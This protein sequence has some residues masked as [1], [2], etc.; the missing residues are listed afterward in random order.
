MS[1]A[2]PDVLE[3]V[4]QQGTEALGHKLMAFE[5][6][7]E[8]SR[9]ISALDLSTALG[10]ILRSI[11]E[12]TGT[13]RGVL[14]LEDTDGQLRCE[15]AIHLD[16]GAWQSEELAISRSV[17]EQARTSGE[18]V[19]IDD[20]P[21]SSS[22]D[23]PSIIELGLRALMAIPLRGRAGVF[24]VLYADTRAP[25]P[26]MAGRDPSI[27]LAFGLQAAIAIEN[28]RTHSELR[29]DCR[30]LR[31]SLETPTDFD[32]I[33]YRS[34]SMEKVCELIRS[35]SETDIT[36]LI[37]GETGTGKELVAQ[38]IR[39]HSRR[40]RAPFVSQN[41]G[42]LTDSLLESELF[43]HRRG[44]FSGALDHKPG[45]F[46]VADG[47]TVFLDEVAEASTAL[48]VRLLRLLETGTFRRV[49]ETRD[50]STDVRVI[51]ATHR[52]LP[53]ELAAGRF[54]E[55]LFYRLNVFPIYLPPLRERRE[56]IPILVEHFIARYVRQLDRELPPLPASILRYLID[57]PWPGNVRQLKNFVHRMVVL[58]RT[59]R[60]HLPDEPAAATAEPPDPEELDGETLDPERVATLEQVER[61]HVRRVL[62]SVG[63]NQTRAAG[64]LGLKRSTLRWRMKK[65]G[66][67]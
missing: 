38:A 24:G 21:S 14:L 23:R 4:R 29:N 20:A 3:L 67:S 40:C 61:R 19:M 5:R 17:V 11:L 45:L 43:G 28:A 16:V 22:A 62:D 31:S 64:L 15:L 9:R 26:A 8:I 33:L 60:W 55:D 12:L 10:M 57:R 46:E 27:L 52:E 34:R 47:G 6:L 48:Q 66:I 49:G 58:S 65:L 25:A 42:A 39:K 37:Q 35:A 32:G 7:L 56:D 50:R 18:L 54:R 41:A 36:V 44:A 13:Q 63:G 2:P 59:G 51:A 30:A 1:N 53:S